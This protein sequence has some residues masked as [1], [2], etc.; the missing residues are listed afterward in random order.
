MSYKLVYNGMLF[1][2]KETGKGV[3]LHYNV[4]KGCSDIVNFERGTTKEKVLGW[5]K[6]DPRFNK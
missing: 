2:V 1:W 5:L 3:Q 4:N 6:F